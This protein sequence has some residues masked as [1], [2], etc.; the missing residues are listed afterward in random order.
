MYRLPNIIG[1]WL[2]CLLLTGCGAEQAMKKGDKFFSMGEYYD[3]ATQ[4]KKAYAQTPAKERQLRGQRALKMAECYRRINYA[5]RAIAAYNNAIRYKQQDSLTNLLLAQQL[6][7]NGDYKEAEK[8][9]IV[10]LDS[11]AKDQSRF[12][13]LNS[14]LART[15]LESARKASDW[16]KQGSKYT[17]KRMDIF[18]SRRADYSPML[19][20]DQNDQLFRI[21]GTGS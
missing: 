1:V 20:G 19:V 10:A 6:M 18:N 7:K 21:T 11:L 16:K 14:Q 13:I 4:Y 15:G 5:Q 8:S 17:V 9:F 3:A 12:S 2:Y